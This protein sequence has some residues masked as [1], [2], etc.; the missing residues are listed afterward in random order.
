VAISPHREVELLSK[1]RSSWRIDYYTTTQPTPFTATDSLSATRAYTLAGLTNG[2][3]YTI[4]LSTVDCA[5]P[6]SD[7]VHVMPT[8]LFVYLPLVLRGK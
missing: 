6:L 1:W 7:T 3:W 8:N 4:T 5:P 2:D